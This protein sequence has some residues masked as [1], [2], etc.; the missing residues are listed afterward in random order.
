MGVPC[1]SVSFPT[2]PTI[3][4]MVPAI[5]MRVSPPKT[6]AADVGLPSGFHDGEVLTRLVKQRHPVSGL[7]V[8]IAVS[9]GGSQTGHV[10]LLIQSLMGPHDFAAQSGEEEFLLIFPAERGGSAQRR[11]CEV[12]QELWDFQLNSRKTCSILFSWGGVEVSGESIDDAIESANERMEET[13]RKRA[14]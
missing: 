10:P 13:R 6:P 12:A 4:G 11:L 9:G 2:G 8:S 14:G 5:R 1:Y 3:G 7:V